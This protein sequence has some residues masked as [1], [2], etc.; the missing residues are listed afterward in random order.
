MV[1]RKKT[2]FAKARK[3]VSILSSTPAVSSL[4]VVLSVRLGQALDMVLEYWRTPLHSVYGYSVLVA[5][6]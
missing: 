2:G 4:I 6:H 5:L 3:R 1:E